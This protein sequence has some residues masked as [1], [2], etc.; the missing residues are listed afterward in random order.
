MSQPSKLGGGDSQAKVVVATMSNCTHCDSAKT[1]FAN[2]PNFNII[3][4]HGPNAIDPNHPMAKHC[5]AEGFPTF[6]KADGSTCA[7]G[8]GGNADEIRK[9]CL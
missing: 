5:K 6:K 8:F 9:K 7:V 2:D 3:Q 4:C 1:A